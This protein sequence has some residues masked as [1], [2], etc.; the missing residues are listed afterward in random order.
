MEIFFEDTFEEEIKII[1]KVETEPLYE[2]YLRGTKKLKGNFMNEELKIE[3]N[4][5]IFKSIEKDYGYD[6]IFVNDI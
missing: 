2:K 6:E 1:S 3:N 4:T 5:R